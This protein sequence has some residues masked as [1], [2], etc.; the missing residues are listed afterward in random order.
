VKLL[1]DTQALIWFASNASHL[2]DVAKNAISSADNSLSVSAATFWELGIKISIG[3]LRLPVSIGEFMNR[4]LDGYG[5][6]L[7]PILPVH[8][9]IISSM[10]FHHKDPFDRMVAAQAL[11]SKSVIVSSDSCFD[12]YGAERI[13]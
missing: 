7:E 12:L 3:K 10:Q 5:I 2:T 8:V 11:S 4:T 6:A 9:E 1:I 13:W